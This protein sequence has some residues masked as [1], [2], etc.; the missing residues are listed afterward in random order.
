MRREDCDSGPLLHELLSCPLEKIVRPVVDSSGWRSIWENAGKRWTR[1]I[2]RSV[3][4]G[5]ACDRL[6]WVFASGYQAAIQCLYPDLPE[7]TV[8]AMCISEAGGNHPRA[9]KSELTLSDHGHLLNGEK[10]FVTGGE[11]ANRLIVAASTGSADGLNQL[12]MAWVERNT[13]GIHLAPGPSLPF[14]PELTHCSAIF[15]NVPVPSSNLLPGDGYTTAIK[16][17]RTIEDLHVS[18]AVLGHLLGIARRFDWPWDVVGRLSLLIA[19][20][21]ALA[22]EDPLSPATHVAMGGFFDQLETLLAA[23]TPLWPAVENFIYSRWQRDQ[24]ALRIA[25]NA[26][27]LRLNAAWRHYGQ[28]LEKSNNPG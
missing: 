12:R 24:P 21:V 7:N 23:L 1:P 22:D 11:N 9:I 16:P 13:I 6:A 10:R 4:A 28:V 18:G 5:L 15:R 19:G 25:D 8:A 2:H 20:A 27:Q 17:F 14:M 3:F 26:R